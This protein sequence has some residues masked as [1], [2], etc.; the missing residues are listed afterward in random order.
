MRYSIST[1]LITIALVLLSAPPAYAS[2]II[3]PANNLGLVGYWN[4]NEGTGIRAA[5]SSGNGNTGTLAGTAAWVGGKFGSG[6]HTNSDTE[7]VDIPS[8]NNNVTYSAITV[9][10]WFYESADPANHSRLIANAHTDTDNTG[11]QMWLGPAGDGNGCTNAGTNSV[12][13]DVGA[14]GTSNCANTGV[15]L[16]A[17][18]WYFLVGTYDG[19]TINI[20]QDGVLKEQKNFTGGA[21]AVA[22]YDV[23]ISE[24]PAYAGDHFNGTSDDVR[25]YKRALSATEIATMYKYGASRTGVSSAALNGTGL[26]S[27]LVGLWTFD[28]LDVNWSTSPPLT[29]DKSG[30]G[31][32][33]ALQNMNRS[34]AAV[35]K[36]GQGIFLNGTT[37]YAWTTDSAP[38]DVGDIF[39]YSIW[40]KRTRTGVNYETLFSKENG[41]FVGVFDSSD[42][43]SF[44]IFNGGNIL[45]SNAT[46][47]DFNWH[48][49]VFTKNGSAVALYIDGA[50]DKSGSTGITATN[51]TSPQAIGVDLTN[52]VDP[53][54]G[55][56]FKGYI[57]DVRIYNRALST[58][59][60]KQLYNLGVQ[61]INASS[62]TLTSGSSLA[63]G[64]VGLWTFD[65][66]DV[67]DKVYDRSGQSNNGYYVGGATSSAKVIGKLG[68]ALNFDGSHYINIGGL[69]GSPGTVTLAEWIN[70][71]GRGSSAADAMSIGDIAIIRVDESSIALSCIYHGGAYHTI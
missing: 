43:A 57:D 8:L 13:F 62:Q 31:G 37:A 66:P 25:I 15:D 54:P 49:Y 11:F 17:S 9:S 36:L 39:T 48:H 60:V 24:D 30:N 16:V 26:S 68:Q 52:A 41:T 10:G 35:G 5:D 32:T 47:T 14:G 59:T 63:S 67:T 4:F 44:N 61:K 7:Y 28:N 40:A 69:M 20:Y 19:A 6:V 64:L 50:L 22:P 53:N 51:N 38:L 1:F 29:T 21:I 12:R 55:T 46:I 70:M 27:G 33:A 42:H 71:T 2:L 34:N 3:K 56:Y 18:R 65:G 58:T 45:T 23:Y